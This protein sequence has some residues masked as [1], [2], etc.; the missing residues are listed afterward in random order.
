MGPFQER[1]RMI[2]L[3]VDVGT[4]STKAVAVDE[5]G[6]VLATRRRDHRTSSPAPGFFEHDVDAVWLGEPVDLLRD[7]LDVLHA[8]LG[9][10]PSDVSGVAFSG[11]GPAIVPADASAA[12]LRPGILYGI[13]TR[14]QVEIAAANQELGDE[15]LMAHCGNLLSS[16]S[17]GPKL[18][19]VHDHEPDVWQ[20]TSKIF[21]PPSYVVYRLTGE[22]VFDRYTAS[23]A[24]PLYDMTTGNWWDAGW[25]TVPGSD[26]IERP[27]LVDPVEVVGSLHAAGARLTGLPIGTPVIAGTVDALAESYSVGVE[28]AGDMMLM[29]GSTL[30]MIQLTEAFSPAQPLWA[31]GGLR[32]DQHALAAG[33]STGGLVTSWLSDQLGVSVGELV[34]EADQ[35]PPGSHGLVLLPYL[36]GERTPFED[37]LAR[38]AWV[39]LGLR[40]TRADLARSA[41]ESIGFGIRHNIEKM[42]E[43][44]A[45]PRRLVAVGGGAQS[46]QWLQIVSDICQAP[47]DAPELTVGAAYG[48]ARMAALAAGYD[49][50]AWNPP[51]YTVQ[52]RAEFGP[53]YDDLFDVYTSLYSP[54]RD[55]MHRLSAYNA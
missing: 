47:Q 50:A 31:V 46:R 1:I 23:G 43:L 42:V 30:F 45:S 27:R 19:W 49:V 4:G 41:L 25:A 54:L 16:Q 28:S 17:I 15:T 55:T 8:E 10:S 14:A 44:G 13:D 2:F 18:A 3:G 12:P 36:S 34:A 24:D 51:S 29:Y 9:A 33:M 52:P 6:R 37:P 35:A 40:H 20:A 48:D 22:Y 38:G 39:G 53:L 11:I 7:L 5:A 32:R 26:A 21:C